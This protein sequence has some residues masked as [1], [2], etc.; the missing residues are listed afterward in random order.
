M[1]NL[2]RFIMLDLSLIHPDPQHTLQNLPTSHGHQKRATDQVQV[3]TVIGG[4]DGQSEKLWVGGCEEEGEFEWMEEDDE[5][6]WDR[7]RERGGGEEFYADVA[8][9]DQEPSRVSG[10]R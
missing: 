10:L 8:G 2:F 5:E 1:L 6:G 3:T 9:R 7:E 4:L